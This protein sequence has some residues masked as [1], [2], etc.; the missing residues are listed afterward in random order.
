MRLIIELEMDN[1]SFHP[2]PADPHG[3]RFEAF[4][5]LLKTAS[6]IQ[7]RPEMSADGTCSM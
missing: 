1:A 6:L 7:N 2:D 4:K 3:W 5:V